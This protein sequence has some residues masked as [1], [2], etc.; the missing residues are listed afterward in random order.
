MTVTRARRSN[1]SCASMVE[2]AISGPVLLLSTISVLQLC[3]AMWN[4]ESLAFAVREGARYASTKGQGCSYGTNSCS[5]TVGNVTNQILNNAVGLIPADLNVT[6]GATSSVSITC[7]PI[8]NCT[9]NGSAWPPS[10]G[11]T[12]GV[13]VL[14]VSATYPFSLFF[15][16]QQGVLGV[17]S[18]NLQA[19]SQQVVQF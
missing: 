16:P 3:L 11:N 5:T 8:T 4:Y 7:S 6:L 17:S 12:E 14:T 13:S 1:Q 15:M 10:T 19:S 2:F 9:K 18:G